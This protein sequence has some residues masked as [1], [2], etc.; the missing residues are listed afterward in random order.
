[1]EEPKEGYLIIRGRVKIFAWTNYK[2]ISKE[3]LIVLDQK[4]KA[5]LLDAV[6]RA[7]KNKRSTVLPHDL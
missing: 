4:L 3:S 1:M 2:R 7:D 5:I 6:K